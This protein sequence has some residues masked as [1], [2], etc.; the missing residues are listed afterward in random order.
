[1]LNDIKKYYSFLINNEE[2]KGTKNK[3]IFILIIILALFL[4]NKL[5]LVKYAN[6]EYF[7]IY[8]AFSK[9]LFI[10][11]ISPYSKDISSI[12][13]NY[14]ST[15]GEFLS[16][17]NIIFQLPI[18]Q[19]IFY[20]PFSIIPSLN[21]SFLLWLTFNQSIFLLCIVNCIKILKW[22]PKKWTMLIIL[23]FGLITFFGISNFLAANTAIIQL[24]FLIMGLKAY[25]FKR[26]VIA[27]I[28]IGLA[29]IDPFYFFIPLFTIL[30]FL[31]SRKHFKPIFWTFIS[32]VLLSLG[33]IIFDSG[34]IL[35]YSRNIILDGS[36]FPF[37]DYNHALLNWISKLNLGSLVNFVPILLVI[38]ILIE[39]S[40]LPKQNS[41]QLFWI[42]SLVTCINPFVTMR[43]TNYSSVLYI[44]PIIFIIYLW[45]K[46]STGMLKKV[47]YG[48]VC[49][50]AVFL[51]LAALL[52]P[53]TFLFLLNFHS[54]NL[55]NSIFLLIVLY[56]I[57][58]W[59][60]TPYDYLITE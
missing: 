21:W 25:F 9:L 59:V 51:P 26:Y 12:L 11:G 57:R 55:I 16:F 43:E 13:V 44:F 39:Y 6:S 49:F 60:V 50:T 35:K 27:G 4:I 38:W 7:Q 17:N 42:L 18:Y 58:W 48:I 40:R 56:W 54:I 2:G 19:L 10:K 34:W 32:I 14:F 31:L 23:G 52:F 24:F 3:I 41:N 28:L 45:E 15:Q 37:I 8:S 33:G 1:M 36:F 53:R 47:V 29:T 30:F 20:L 46:R 22:E 5:F